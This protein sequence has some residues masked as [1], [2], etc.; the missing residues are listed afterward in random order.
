VLLPTEHPLIR[1]NPQGHEVEV[2]F[3]ER[4]WVFPQSDC[5]L[6]PVSNTTTEL[7]ASYFGRRLLDQLQADPAMR[8]SRVRVEVEESPG[9]SAMCELR[10]G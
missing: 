1:V 2:R 6:L 9:L 4:R 7:L 10:E 3:A 5:L 8:P